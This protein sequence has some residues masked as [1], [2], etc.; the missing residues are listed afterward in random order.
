MTQ[1]RVR[2][3]R[4]PFVGAL[5]GIGLLSLLRRRRKRRP[6][7]AQLMAMDDASFAAFIEST[8]LKTVTSAG[9]DSRGATSD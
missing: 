2:A 5:A 6:N 1:L 8:G 4:L 7:G 9:L 3:A